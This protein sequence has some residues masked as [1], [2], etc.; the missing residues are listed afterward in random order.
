MPVFN[1][2]YERSGTIWVSTFPYTGWE[3]I[4]NAFPD[5]M[6]SLEF[7]DL[8]ALREFLRD[9]YRLTASELDLSLEKMKADEPEPCCI[10]LYAP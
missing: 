6:S 9:E 2:I 4:Q 7:K 3:A 10:R 8:E 1:L 5:Y